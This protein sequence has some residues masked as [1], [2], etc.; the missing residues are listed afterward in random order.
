MLVLRYVTLR[1]V[2]L[3]F[4]VLRHVTLRYITLNSTSNDTSQNVTQPYKISYRESVLLASYVVLILFDKTTSSTTQSYRR[5]VV[6]GRHLADMS[7]LIFRALSSPFPT[8]VEAALRDEHI[9]VIS[10]NRH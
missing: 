7:W 3:R 4:V 6:E 8:I 1:Y 9:H 5:F 2:A 10:Y